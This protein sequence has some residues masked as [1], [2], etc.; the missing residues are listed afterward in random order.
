MKIAVFGLGLIGG[1]IAKELSTRSLGTVEVYGI[2]KNPDHARQAID[3]KLVNSILTLEEAIEK[4]QVFILA[5]PVN[6]IENVLLNVLNNIKSHQVVFDVGST[7]KEICA[8]IKS[9]KNRS[10]FVA[11][12][13]LA[14]TE[15]S[16]PQAAI[17]GLFDGK[18]NIICE[19]ALS[20][21][22][23]IETT[24]KIFE[25]LG[26]NSYFLS[27]EEHDKHMAYVSHLSHVTSFALSQTVLDIEKDEKQIFNMASTGFAS[28]ARLAKCNPITWTAIF[29]KNAKYLSEALDVYIVKMKAFKQLVDKIDTQGMHASIEEANQIERVLKGI[30]LNK[31]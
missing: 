4:C 25:F 8:S 27:S 21:D 2:E 6:A 3:L 30:K 12:H 13:P 7:K 11:A 16:G 29:E 15:F 1:S 5:V 26:M 9:H 23:A 18:K 14:G 28:T 10:R 19:K 31:K 24:L 20:D 22:D 17:L